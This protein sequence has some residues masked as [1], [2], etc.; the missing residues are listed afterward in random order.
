M[1]NNI[2]EQAPRDSNNPMRL[3]VLVSGSGTI[4][5]ALI[6]ACDSGALPARIELVLSNK[7][8]APALDRARKAEINVRIVPEEAF[9]SATEQSA[10]IVA[11]LQQRDVELVCLG[12]FFGPSDAQLS[13]AFGNR[14]LHIHGSLLPAFPE[15]HPV[16]AALDAGAKITGCTLSFL[17]AQGNP[18]AI[19][20]QS[21]VLISPDDDEEALAVRVH[22]LQQRCFVNGLK[23]ISQGLVHLDNDT[24]VIDR[25]IDPDHSLEWWALAKSGSQ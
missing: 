17:N 25:N 5:Q 18:G 14:I 12:N 6:S 13:Q 3:G 9:S 10:A 8:D 20:L 21:A 1:A 22:I 2:I 15:M 11:A 16:R 23:M 19:F 24:L 7:K 4:L